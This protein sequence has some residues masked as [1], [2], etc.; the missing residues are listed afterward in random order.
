LGL[1]NMNSQDPALRKRWSSLAQLAFEDLL[2]LL[3]TRSRLS[4]GTINSFRLKRDF[5]A[6]KKFLLSAFN[7]EAFSNLAQVVEESVNENKFMDAMANMDHQVLKRRYKG[8]RT[9]FYLMTGVFTTMGT[10][11][12]YF[13]DSRLLGVLLLGATL[14]AVIKDFMSHNI[15]YGKRKTIQKADL[16][17]ELQTMIKRKKEGAPNFRC[18]GILSF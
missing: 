7:Q 1:N 6:T 9:M 15:A 2:E 8:Q 4:N 10:G 18:A 16:R 11:L 3:A 14:R 5:T 13:H 12:L 17:K